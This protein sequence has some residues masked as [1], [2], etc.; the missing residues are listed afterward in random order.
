MRT[1]PS[2][3]DTEAVIDQVD[4]RNEWRRAE[5]VRRN[6]IIVGLSA[7]LIMVGIA[8]GTATAAVGGKVDRVEFAEHVAQSDRRF[9]ST[10]SSGR[11]KRPRCSGSRRSSTRR[12]RASRA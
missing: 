12:T 6:V 11:S 4:H 8:W 10:R 3:I 2:S 1:P 5:D 7:A 9:R